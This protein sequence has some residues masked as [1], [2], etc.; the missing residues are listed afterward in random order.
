MASIGRL[1]ARIERDLNVPAPEPEETITAGRH[2]IRTRDPQM[3]AVLRDLSAAERALELVKSMRKYRP[4]DPR[5]SRPGGPL[6]GRMV[7]VTCRLSPEAFERVSADAARDG[8]SVTTKV[9]E[10]VDRK[11]KRR[12]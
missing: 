2:T 4:E 3:K 5:R 8:V 6:P 10:L 1:H 11:P 9:R 12:T 7:Q